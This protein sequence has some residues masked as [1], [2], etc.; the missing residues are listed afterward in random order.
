MSVRRR[1]GEGATQQ[2]LLRRLHVLGR[3]VEI[4]THVFSL[5]ASPTDHRPRVER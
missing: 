5:D 3:G 4:G 2:R 1:I